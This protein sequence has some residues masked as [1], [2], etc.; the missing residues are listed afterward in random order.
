MIESLNSVQKRLDAFLSLSR[1]RFWEIDLEG[2]C[3]YHNKAFNSRLNYLPDNIFKCHQA[4]LHPD[5]KGLFV[6]MV[7]EAF[8]LQRGWTNRPVKLLNS[9]GSFTEVWSSAQLMRNEAGQVE[10]LAIHDIPLDCRVQKEYFKLQAEK[11]KKELEESERRYQIIFEESHDPILIIKNN[12]FVECNQ[13]TLNCLQIASKEAF[14]AILPSEISPIWQPDGRLSEEKQYE[15]INLALEKGS[16]T[17]EWLHQKSNG[18]TMWMDVSLTRITINYEVLLYV[19]WRNITA[20]KK[21][22]FALEEQQAQLDAIINTTL[23][24]VSILDKN[25]MHLFANNAAEKIHGVPAPKILGT[26]LFQLLHPDDYNSVADFLRQLAS[27]ETD[28]VDEEIRL[29]HQTDKKLVW[30]HIN[31]TRYKLSLQPNAENVLIVFQDITSLKKVENALKEALDTKDK[32]FNIIA[33]DL[34]SPFTAIMGFANIL[35]RDNA[36]STAEERESIILPMIDSIRRTY[37]LL[38]N[39]LDWAR[40]QTGRID[41]K[42]ELLPVG[43]LVADALSDTRHLARKKE[44]TIHKEFKL[45]LELFADCNILRVVLR[46]LLTN[47]IKFTAA[48]G[49]IFIGIQ[50]NETETEFAVRDTGI[51]IA[52][53]KLAS[54]F[55]AG[56]IQST[57]GTGSEKGTG[58]GLLL[59]K[60]LI[61]KHRGSISVQSILGEGSTF[62]FR[63]P[64]STDSLK[65]LI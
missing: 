5:D 27:H 55:N 2:N 49:S 61:D 54:L 9:D 28:S 31:V 45:D 18:E 42:P 39:L 7:T 1:S 16:H 13:A 17:F 38:E 40:A 6:N 60:E 62:R 36:N 44:I 24:G 59:C 26:S 34:R 57:N 10:G 47:A 52:P 22:Q 64:N 20:R 65:Q 37:N 63:I 41:F 15:M 8:R 29:I 4:Y 50:Q 58:L 25:G 32:F 35:Q 51:G 53:N 30:I 48:G 12:R 3:Y 21:A 11:T 43:L 46:N 14:R 33:H 56:Y 19:V 23:T